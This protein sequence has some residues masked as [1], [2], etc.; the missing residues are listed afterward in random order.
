[1]K[2]EQNKK[3]VADKVLA[4]LLKKLRKIKKLEAESIESYALV[5]MYQNCRENG[6]TV[7]CGYYPKNT[8]GS[9]QRTVYFSEARSS[10]SIAIYR[11]ETYPINQ[12]LTEEAYK[13]SIYIGVG[14]YEEAAE[15]AFQYLT[16]IP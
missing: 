10:D 5:G 3:K 2:I 12:G 15:K 6:Y 13:N 4:L 9:I 1:M 14:E 16:M 8:K 7:S 11:E